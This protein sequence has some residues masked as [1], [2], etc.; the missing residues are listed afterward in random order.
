MKAEDVVLGSK[1]RDTVSGYTGIAIN[2]TEWMNG[3]WRV[4]LQANMKDTKD[5]KPDDGWVVDVEQIVPVGRP[6]KKKQPKRTGGG[7]PSP[8]R[9]RDPGR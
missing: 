2:K 9:R 7:R 8:Q 6:K 3:C 4:Q 1:Y 5:G